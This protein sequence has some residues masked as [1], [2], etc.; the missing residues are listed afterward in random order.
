[1]VHY[2]HTCMTVKN[3]KKHCFYRKLDFQVATVGLWD[4]NKY[5]N[6]CMNTFEVGKHAKKDH[7]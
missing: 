4:V 6:K 7:D 1:M 3:V 2:F 5:K